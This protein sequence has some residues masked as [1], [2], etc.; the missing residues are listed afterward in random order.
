MTL[1]N[2][3]FPSFH[4]QHPL[5][6]VLVGTLLESESDPVVRA[7]L[8]VARA[9]GARVLLVH[10]APGVPPIGTPSPR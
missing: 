1:Q 5:R 9:A 8:A 2:R 7:G 10:A 4:P 3:E 6:T